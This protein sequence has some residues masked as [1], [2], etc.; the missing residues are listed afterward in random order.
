MENTRDIQRQ[1]DRLY[2]EM[3]DIYHD[4]AVGLGLSDSAMNVLYS[5]HVL[6][7]GC[8]QRDICRV[9]FMSKQTIHSSVGKL[10]AQGILRMEPGRGRDR[11]LHLTPAGKEIVAER[12]VPVAAAEE[13]AFAA[14]AGEEQRE[15][16][17]LT[18]QYVEALRRETRH[19]P[20]E[21]GEDL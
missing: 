14:L 2:K 11:H 17:R 15:L 7:D 20:V 6:G 18:R 3:D 21:K 12:I 4:L 10:C 9:S 1:F 5:L 19:L 16:L 8:L 13:R